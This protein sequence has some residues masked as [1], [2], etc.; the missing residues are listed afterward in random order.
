MY[1]NKILILGCN[2][3]LGKNLHTYFENNTYLDKQFFF[4]EKKNIDFT[5]KIKLNEYFHNLKPNVV[6]NCSGIV[7]NTEL[8]K[9]KDDNQIFNDNILLN[10]IIIECCQRNNVE[11]LILFSSYRIFGDN[12]MSGYNEQ[13]IYDDFNIENN[14]GYLLSKKILDIQIKLCIKNYNINV[15][16]LIL[17]NIFGEH[18]NFITEGK[19]VASFIKKIYDSNTNNT[20]LYINSNSKTKV[21]LIYV[22]DIINIIN[23]CIN[24]NTITGNIIVYNYKSIFTLE[25]LIIKISKIMNYNKNIYF[26]NNS[27]YTKTNIMTPNISLFHNFFPYFKFTKI[28]YALQKTIQYFYTTFTGM[29]YIKPTHFTK[30]EIA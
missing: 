29:S 7:G 5:D 16:C 14:S 28:D 10:S 26:N 19:I 2:G 17:P 20:D 9:K 30:P 21:N 15:I 24:S 13:N 23:K 4:L 22:K 3:F 11:K 27:T 12:I 18:D 6:I 8:N 1:K 25:Q